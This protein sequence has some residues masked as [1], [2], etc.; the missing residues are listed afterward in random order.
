VGSGVALMQN[1][2]APIEKIHKYNVLAVSYTVSGSEFLETINLRFFTKYP[3]SQSLDAYVFL[4]GSAGMWEL[5][6]SYGGTF[7]K[8]I[9]VKNRD[10]SR[11]QEWVIQV[12]AYGVQV[13]EN[14]IVANQWSNLLIDREKISASIVIQSIT[15][16][17]SQM[18]IEAS[19]TGDT[20]W[21]D[22]HSVQ[23][24]VMVKDSGGGI[25]GQTSQQIDILHGE[26]ETYTWNIG[27]SF[28]KGKTYTVQIILT[29]LPTGWNIA[30]V[31]QRKIG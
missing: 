16:T 10:G 23:A 24:R 3:P 31:E 5:S 8:T 6:T 2:T 20:M 27:G 19:V 18:R 26:V 30:T 14:T 29:Y 21:M 22:M 13:P 17:A 15:A 7:S 4:D 1:A 25:I 28:Q 11:P 9:D 12:W